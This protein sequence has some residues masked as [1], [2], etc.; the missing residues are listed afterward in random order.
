[1]ERPITEQPS[2]PA[3]RKKMTKQLTGKR[4]DTALHSAARAGNL[5]A[6]KE[7]L[8]GIEEDALKEQLAKQNHSGETALYVA[9]E[10]GYVDLVKEMI[11]YYDLV[12]A[13]IKARN[14]FDALHIAA[15]QG[16]LDILKVLLAAHPELAM[17]VDLS[18]TTALHTAATQGHIENV[19][20]LLE[21]GSSLAIIARSNGKTPLHSASRNGHLDVVK[22]LLACEPGIAPRIDKKGQT[23]LHMAVKGQS[24]A[25]VEEL[26]RVNP[27]LMINMVDTKGNTS[28]HIATRKGRAQIVKLLLGYKETDIKAVNRC[29]ETAFDIA[30]KTGHLEIASMLQQHGVQSARAI[31]P[32]ATNPARE[33]KQ[34][35]SD[36]KHEVH[37]QL[38]HTLQTRK[39]VQGIAKRINKMHSEGL[40]NAINSTTVVAVLI[41]TVAFAAIFTVPGQ[42]VDDPNDIPPGDS[43][44]EANIAPKPAFI[45]FFIFDSIALFISL[46]VVV[47]QTSV[48][49]IDS[50]GKKQMM[51]IINKLMWLACVLVSVAFLALSFIV[52]G[53][54]EKWLAIGVTIIGT[55]IMATT[56]GTM[57]YWVIRHRIE[58]SNMRSIRRSS[59]ASRSRSWTMSVMS[60]SE[61]LNNEFKKMYAI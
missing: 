45:I 56:L 25:V 7:I 30:E 22:A 49:V 4:D 38:E 58:A 16:D 42:Y 17:T 18:N 37:Y 46:A 29:G 53:K 11:N 3:R 27:S 20:F 52:V 12:N 40:N 6:V 26:I 34:T 31:K 35:V 9:A 13:G 10:Y 44:G 14:G 39:Q 57:C 2:V 50:K 19:K 61:I 54:D 60:D 43:L 32:A 48:V 36:I 59:Q 55:S 8:T 51:A 33:L 21:V 15:K 5:A 41:A 1:M 47:V 28:L 24:L 23:A